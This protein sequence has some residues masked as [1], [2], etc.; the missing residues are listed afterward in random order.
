M[1]CSSLTGVQERKKSITNSNKFIPWR[2]I[3]RNAANGRSP[4]LTSASVGKISIQY[5]Q[6]TKEHTTADVLNS[7]QWTFANLVNAEESIPLSALYST[8]ERTCLIPMTTIARQLYA[9]RVTRMWL[10]DVKKT[11]HLPSL[12]RLAEYERE[13]MKLNVKYPTMTKRMIQNFQFLKRR[14]CKKNEESILI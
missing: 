6:N 8:S 11:I 9:Y 10:S 13:V 14:H 12:P 4:L 3:V 1:K 7:N 5:A 2:S